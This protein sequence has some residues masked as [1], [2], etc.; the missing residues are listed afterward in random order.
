M[1]LKKIECCLTK[2]GYVLFRYWRKIINN[3]F[4]LIEIETRRNE[5]QVETREFVS[6]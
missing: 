2:E 3:S 6:V 4:I 5:F 1:K